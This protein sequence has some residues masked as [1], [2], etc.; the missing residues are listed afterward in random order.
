MDHYLDQPREVAL[1]TYA[2][3]NAA[4][5]FCPYPTL[6]RIGEKMSDDLIID[7]I[8]QMSE[9]DK[10]FYFSPFKV[11]EPLLDKRLITICKDVL[12]NTN[13]IIRL[14]SNGSALTPKKIEE[15]ATLDRLEH[16]W[17]SLN[18]YRAKEYRELMNLDFENTASKLDYLHESGFP[19]RVVLSTVGFPNEE[20]RRY[21]FDRWPNFESFAIHRSGWLGD[22]EPQDRPIPEHECGRWWEMSIM[23]NGIVSLCCMDGQGKYPQG[24]VKAESLLD[25]YA[26]MREHR[27]RKKRD[28]FPCNT[29]NNH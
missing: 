28:W 24:D 18:D 22:I 9:W 12:M 13:G 1:E 6:D 27:V 17:I 5:V 10:P 16:L 8:D 15:I 11:N 3:C 4:C 29:C 20:F 21:C 7:L 19:F 23:A 25:I 14:F 2:K 26:K